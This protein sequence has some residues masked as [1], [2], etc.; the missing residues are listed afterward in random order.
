ME[1]RRAARIRR[2]HRGEPGSRRRHPRHRGRAQNPLEPARHRQTQRRPG[3]LFYHDAAMPLYLLPIYAKAQ[4]ENWT[5][6]EKKRVRTLVTQIE[7]EY[8]R[9]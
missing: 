3:H 7:Q 4:R 2:L 8:R 1:G 6:D 5:Q 9:R